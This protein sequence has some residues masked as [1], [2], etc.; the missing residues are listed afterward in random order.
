M[1]IEHYHYFNFSK[2]MKVLAFF[3]G[4]SFL[5]VAAQAQTIAYSEILKKDSKSMDFEILGNVQG[6]TLIY[7]IIDDN[8][9]LTIYDNSMKLLN[10]VKLDFISDRT[11]NIEFVVYPQFVYAVYQLQKGGNVYSKMAKI[12]GQGNLIGEV[13]NLDTARV[14]FFSPNK[15][16]F[17]NVSDNKER[18]LLYKLQTRNDE[19]QLAA[20]V[21]NGDFQKVD[22]VILKIENAN[23]KEV[24]SDLKVANDGNIYFVKQHRRGFSDYMNKSELYIKE[25][26]IEGFSIKPVAEEKY[27][28][29]EMEV[30]IDNQNK[31]VFANCFTY[32]SNVGNASGILTVAFNKMTGEEK[33]RS[34]I[35]FSDSLKS[36]LTSKRRRSNDPFANFEIKSVLNK[37]DSGLLITLEENFEESRG[38]YNNPYGR[39]SFL[40][41]DPYYYNNNAGFYRFQRR[42]YYD[43]YYNPYNSSSNSANILYNSND[44]VM[45][46]IGGDLDLQWE[47]VI[48]KKQSDIESENHLSYGTVNLGGQI[49]YLYLL[50]DNNKEVISD[51][52]LMPNGVIKRY[53]TIKSGQKGYSFMPRLAKQISS[54]SIVVPAVTRNNIAFVK[55]FFE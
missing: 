33:G 30:K 23:R 51:N 7:K 44:V 5:L 6:N 19:L 18:I 36:K 10:D 53:A 17:L 43:N 14:G 48:N 37:R 16:Y 11:F 42:G 1:F 41:Y 45:M 50:R 49:H 9:R 27:F 21:Y 28:L 2:Y 15:V 35:A 4:F 12:D 3:L 38:N 55:M 52:A 40:G 39:S 13:R 32:N 29:D 47:N 54:N 24:F 34:I 22:S 8:H 26:G 46:S 31:I 20:S 25:V